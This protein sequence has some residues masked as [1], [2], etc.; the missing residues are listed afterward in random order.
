MQFHGCQK[1]Y[2]GLQLLMGDEWRSRQSIPRA[3]ASMH[4]PTPCHRRRPYTSYCTQ[5]DKRPAATKN[6][7]PRPPHTLSASKPT[8]EHSTCNHG[9]NTIPARHRQEDRKSAFEPADEQERGY[10]GTSASYDQSE[11]WCANTGL[12]TDV[13][14]RY[15]STTRC[16]CKSTYP[17]FPYTERCET[18]RTVR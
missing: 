17:R 9:T 10:P 11:K 8:W 6:T 4:G 16:L 18:T 14:H 1:L 7:I 2:Q 13:K 5:H 12:K 15:T 3:S